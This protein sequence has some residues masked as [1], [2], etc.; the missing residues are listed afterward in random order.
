MIDVGGQRSERRKWIN[1]FDNI[2]SMVFLVAISEYDQVLRESSSKVSYCNSFN[3]LLI[4]LLINWSKCIP[5]STWLFLYKFYVLYTYL[6]MVYD[7][8]LLL[9]HEVARLNMLQLILKFSMCD[10]TFIQSCHYVATKVYI[11]VI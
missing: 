9:I 11:Y 10:E 5:K 3:F 4:N 2:T 6:T 8:C 7:H 1:C